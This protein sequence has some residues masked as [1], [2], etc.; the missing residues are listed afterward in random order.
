MPPKFE[1]V[2]VEEQQ[3]PQEPV[4]APLEKVGAEN[5]ADFAN[6]NQEIEKAENDNKAKEDKKSDKAKQENERKATIVN[7]IRKNILTD[8]Q[9]VNA[10]SRLGRH[11][12][13]TAQSKESVKIISQLDER[14]KIIRKQHVL[15]YEYRYLTG[16]YKNREALEKEIKTHL[17]NVRKDLTQATKAND[18]RNKK[19]YEDYMAKAEVIRKQKADREAKMA[20]MIRQV[21]Q[22]ASSIKGDLKE[23]NPEA[24]AKVN[25]N[26][27]VNNNEIKPEEKNENAVIANEN[28]VDVNNAA[29]EEVNKENAAANENKPPVNVIVNKKTNLKA[30]FA[31]QLNK[32]NAKNSSNKQVVNNDAKENDKK[33]AEKPDNN[34]NAN[35]V[36]NENVPK[37]VNE[38]IKEEANN[39]KLDNDVTGLKFEQGGEDEQPVLE[40]MN[41]L[42]VKNEPSS[43]KVIENKEQQQNILVNLENKPENEEIPKEIEVKNEENPKENEIKNEELPKENVANQEDALDTDVFLNF[44]DD[45][46]NQSFYIDNDDQEAI[47]AFQ[48]NIKDDTEQKAKGNN[49]PKNNEP[50][51]EKPQEELKEEIENKP[52]EE[53]KENPEE[54]KKPVNPNKP[55]LLFNKANAAPKPKAEKNEEQKLEGIVEV[56]KDEES[57]EELEDLDPDILNN[58]FNAMEDEENEA[59]KAALAEAENG[60]GNNEDENAIKLLPLGG[61]EK[62]DKKKTVKEIAADITQI[63]GVDSKIKPQLDADVAAFLSTLDKVAPNSSPMFSSL[64]SANNRRKFKDNAKLLDANEDEIGKIANEWPK[65]LVPYH[66]NKVKNFSDEYDSLASTWYSLTRQYATSNLGKDRTQAQIIEAI[67]NRSIPKESA[68]AI[69]EYTGIYDEEGIIKLMDRLA[70][71]P[72]L[73]IDTEDIPLKDVESADGVPSIFDHSVEHEQIAMYSTGKNGVKQKHLFDRTFMGFQSENDAEN[74]GQKK[75]GKKGAGK[76]PKNEVFLYYA[77]QL[78]LTTDVIDEDGNLVFSESNSRY[79]AELSK[80]YKIDDRIL[81]NYFRESNSNLEKNEIISNAIR[82]SVFFRHIN[83]IAI[84]QYSLYDAREKLGPAKVMYRTG[85]GEDDVIMYERNNPELDEKSFVIAPVVKEFTEWSQDK[86]SLDATKF[87][88]SLSTFLGDANYIDNPDFDRI[89]SRDTGICSKD[90]LQDLMK[91]FMVI[92]YFELSKHPQIE[93]YQKLVAIISKAL[94]LNMDDEK[95]KNATINDIFTHV[96]LSKGSDWHAVL[97]DSLKIFIPS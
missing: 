60:K 28:N 21:A 51:Q 3:K 18:E 9:D 97:K 52:G 22:S 26:V 42:P 19:S 83:P 67:Q 90:Y 79:I 32:K 16:Q 5:L 12:M 73:K 14:K 38:E 17:M 11:Q 44:G 46:L 94:K 23:E 27:E 36:E 2:K 70:S 48:E 69:V 72:Y 77:E 57:E 49:P 63:E 56:D 81:N 40:E 43:N 4:K 47:A 25:E 29:K 54:A 59:A 58:S 89:L 10:R 61:K 80:R 78:G 93:E 96:K 53:A 20:E 88:E 71:N 62:A 50:E 7:A 84:R 30:L 68:K 85:E 91:I 76:V 1:D 45:G 75:K 33:K 95:I 74:N 35:P 92:D 13:S 55:D 39:E 8:M 37:A 6:N 66:D 82:R 15:D 31:K 86:V 65:K 41:P 64:R 87:K 34:Q 24:K